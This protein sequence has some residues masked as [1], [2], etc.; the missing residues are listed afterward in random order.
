[1]IS[2]RSPEEIEAQNEG[3]RSRMDSTLEELE[4]RLDPAEV[5]RAGIDRLRETDAV[6]Y[7]TAAAVIA[8]RTA[9]EHPVPTALAG[10]G[11]LGLIAWGL[12]PR[13]HRMYRSKTYDASHAI[14]SARAHLSNARRMLE[15]S[16]SDAWQHLGDAGSAARS[17][18]RE[19]PAAAGAIGLALVAIAAA[20]A[21]PSV[22]DRIAGR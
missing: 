16:A 22:R 9:R 3:V 15:D 13:P 4:Q 17:T 7:A 14:G 19:H 1:M 6:R 8:G 2:H 10:I 21:I 20:A 11:V 18:V 12:R 5:V